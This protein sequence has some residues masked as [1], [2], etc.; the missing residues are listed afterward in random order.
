[1]GIFALIKHRG[2]EVI[3][4]DKWTFEEI[5]ALS[6]RVSVLEEKVA[7]LD[8]DDHEEEIQEGLP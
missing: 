4:V 3:K 2:Q 8:P 5:V 1:M 6:S 7:K